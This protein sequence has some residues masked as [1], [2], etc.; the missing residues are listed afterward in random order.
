MRTDLIDLFLGHANAEEKMD[1]TL[2]QY[3]G[4]LDRFDDWL[5]EKHKISLESKDISVVS[6]VMLTEY[7]QLLHS[8]DL[9]VATRR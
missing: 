6:G 7:Y 8:R 5:R 3:G 9:S 2:I 4:V 1:N